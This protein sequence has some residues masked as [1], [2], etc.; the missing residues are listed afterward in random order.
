LDYNDRFAA[1]MSVDDR[2]KERLTGAVILVFIVVLLVPEMFRG[3]RAAPGSDAAAATNPVV[4]AQAQPP[5]TTY[6]LESAPAAKA[7]AGMPP[8]AAATLTKEDSAPAATAA[9]AASSAVPATVPSPVQ[10]TTTTATTPTPLPNSAPANR[11][12]MP[13]NGGSAPKGWIVQVGSFTV[14]EHAERMARQGSKAGMRLSVT[15]P[16]DKGFYRVRSAVLRDRAAAQKVLARYR[17]LGF[18]G[19]VGVAP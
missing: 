15:G 12:V 6:T 14:R 3:R 17:E 10:A 2:L 9:A 19:M 1:R 18:K 7:G 16:D 11:Q 5:A 8:A 4:I 13:V